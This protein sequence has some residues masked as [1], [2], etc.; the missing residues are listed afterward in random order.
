[1]P[2]PAIPIV[3]SEVSSRSLANR[4][5]RR[6][7]PVLIPA[8]DSEVKKPQRHPADGTGLFKPIEYVFYSVTHCFIRV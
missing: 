8:T 6:D 5:S 2:I 1:M 3:Q 7:A 4:N